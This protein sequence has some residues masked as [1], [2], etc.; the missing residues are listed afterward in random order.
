MLNAVEMLLSA[1]IIVLVIMQP[2]KSGDAGNM[3]ASGKNLS[4]FSTSKSRG[5]VRTL[6]IITW[7]LVAVLMTLVIVQRFVG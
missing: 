7:V 4:L 5:G 2:S 6:E 3:L 1:A